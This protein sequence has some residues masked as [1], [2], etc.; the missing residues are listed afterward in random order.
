MPKAIRIYQQGGP[1]VM[2][3]EEVEVGDPGPGQA[4]VRHAAIGLNYIDTY[5][6]SGLY[7]LQPPST[8]GMEGA[9][10]VEAVGSGV[11]DVKQGDRVAYASPPLGS[12]SE[13]RLMPADRLVN[14]PGG[15]AFETAAAMMLKGMTAQYLIKRTYAVRPGQT[16]LFHAAAGGVGLIA[17]QWLS[18]LGVTVIGTVG[19]DAK[20]ALAKAHGCHHTIAYTR[21]NFVERVKELTGGK[22]VPVVYDSVGKDTFQGSLDCLSMF[23]M[24]VSFGNASGPVPSFEPAI[25]AAKGSLFFTRPTL[26]N[27]TAK[28]EDLVASANELFEVVGSGKVKIEIEQRYAL[29]DVVQAHR[30]LEARK[31]AGSTILLP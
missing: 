30:D 29:K 1:E 23:G 9:G 28:R 13:V 10:F 14:L 17:C 19:S 8:L 24:F 26:M 31:T 22:G 25:L 16:V 7:K 5:H 20:A 2:K 4:R 21:E 6:R 15:I 11:K 3:W 27:Y 18:S 12:Y